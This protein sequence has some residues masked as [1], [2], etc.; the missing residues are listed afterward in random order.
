MDP[1]TAGAGVGGGADGAGLDV[2]LGVVGA[3]GSRRGED[4]GLLLLVVASEVVVVVVRFMSLG[5]VKEGM[6]KEGRSGVSE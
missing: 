2:D 5:E 3:R 1:A 4:A 6:T